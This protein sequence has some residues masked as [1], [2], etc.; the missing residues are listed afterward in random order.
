MFTNANSL[1]SSRLNI[2]EYEIDRETL[3]S[4]TGF[5]RQVAEILIQDHFWTVKS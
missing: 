5:Y 2:P 3:S 4:L 1:V